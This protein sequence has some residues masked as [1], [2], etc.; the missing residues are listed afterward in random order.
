MDPSYSP[1][2]T[3]PVPFKSGLKIR[4][5]AAENAVLLDA[6]TGIKVF[7]Y[8]LKG[9]PVYLTE[10]PAVTENGTTWVEVRDLI[11]AGGWIQENSLVKNDIFAS[12]DDICAQEVYKSAAI[13]SSQLFEVG[14]VSLIETQQERYISG[15][16]ITDGAVRSMKISARF[17]KGK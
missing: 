17:R 8:P 9:M 16:G 3:A 10:K 11:G 5:T 7:T 13:T 14:R 15:F 4:Y 2:T 12:L 6:P 1:W